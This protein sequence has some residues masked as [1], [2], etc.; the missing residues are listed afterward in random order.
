[1]YGNIYHM[2]KDH[3]TPRFWISYAEPLEK[4]ISKRV[5]DK[6]LAEDALHDVYVKIYTYCKRF[7][8]C[9]N[10]A[11]VKNLRSWVFQVCHNT[12]IDYYKTQSRYFYPDRFH[13]AIEVES[14]LLKTERQ[15]SIEK[16]LSHLPEKYRQVLTYEFCYSMK[17]S[18]IA[19][20]LGL[21]LPATKSR[22]LRGKQMIAEHYQHLVKSF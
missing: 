8:F 1:L 18:E 6:M 10:K 19:D 7:D 20:K 11:G 15:F 22:I 4:Y 21:S 12:L 13:E 16:I 2:Y 14:L 9:C 17:Q 3:E 5:K